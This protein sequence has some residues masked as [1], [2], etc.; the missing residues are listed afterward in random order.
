MEEIK[1]VSLFPLL[2]KSVKNHKKEKNFKNTQLKRRMPISILLFRDEFNSS[3]KRVETDFLKN[4]VKFFSPNITTKNSNN[5]TD[6][7]KNEY[8]Y[9]TIHNKKQMHNKLSKTINV[10]KIPLYRETKPII[11]KIFDKF[12]E[13]NKRYEEQTKYYDNFN[14]NGDNNRKININR[15]INNYT[16]FSLLPKS[17]TKK[18]CSCAYKRIKAIQD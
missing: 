18:H 6:T 14:K 11:Y 12:K 7:I 2:N 10:K 17:N 9:P 5:Q 1:F 3:N 13:I 16:T 8:K 4:R 15:N